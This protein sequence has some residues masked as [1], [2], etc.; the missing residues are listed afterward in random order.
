MRNPLIRLTSSRIALTCSMILAALSLG[1]RA[2]AQDSDGT[3]LPV[4]HPAAPPAA[5]QS[6][7]M[8]TPEPCPAEEQTPQRDIDV[9]DQV[10]QPGPCALPALS[11]V[12]GSLSKGEGTGHATNAGT[13]SRPGPTASDRDGLSVPPG[14]H[15]ETASSQQERR[16]YVSARTVELPFSDALCPAADDAERALKAVVLYVSGNRGRTWVRAQKRALPADSMSFTAANDGEFWCL[17]RREKRFERGDGPAAGA[18]PHRI[19]TVDTAPPIVARIE[20]L[21][22]ADDGTVTV[23]WEV[24]DR[25]PLVAMKAVVIH[26]RSGAVAMP[27]E[28]VKA[29]AG[30]ARFRLGERGLWHVGAQFAD[31]AGN[32]ETAT[33][34]LRFEPPAPAAA[35]AP[36]ETRNAILAPMAT[37]LTDTVP[38]EPSVA[39]GAELEPSAQVRARERIAVLPTRTLRIGYRWDAEHPPSRVGLWVTPDGGRTWRLDQVTDELTGSFLFEAAGDGPYGFRTHRELAGNVWDA[40]HSGLAPE[41]EI[42]V[43]TTAPRVVWTGPLGDETAGV[44][45]RAPTRV[46]GTV[47]LRWTVTEAFPADR[48]VTLAYRAFA[49]EAWHELAGPM[50]DAGQYDWQPPADLRGPV[51]VR[52]TA[53]DRAGH[54]TTAALPVEIGP[55]LA[56]APPEQPEPDEG[57]DAA[58]VKTSPS[59]A[60]RRAYAMATL[61]RL[62]ENWE[63]AEK[64]LARATALDP[65]YGRAWVDLGGI[66]L[67]SGRWESAVDVYRKALQLEPASGNAGLGLAR[68][69]AARGDLPGAAETLEK[70]LERSPDDADGWLLYGD[71]LYK[72]GNASRARQCWLKSMGLGGGHRANLAAIRQRL[73]LKQ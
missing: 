7:A 37:D 68:A 24:E 58:E 62:Q 28:M 13:D 8:P 69:L 9:P 50:A 22:A 55:A 42:I 64:Q 25:S 52:I 48:P 44:S 29:P 70:L 26:D 34:D 14:T 43:D 15:D 20:A 33:C 49:Q 12:E 45:G 40:P 2:P 31:A 73:Q 39:P 5:N 57:T 11:A 27:F 4:V 46:E 3:L 17:W 51:E 72:G 65:T 63:A 67:H 35:Q 19:V 53:A 21:P 41:R 10:P 32:A 59:D 1:A 60:A 71:V 56:A 54:A 66:Y 61:A 23:A 30:R 38:Q 16:I 36:T 6:A 47:P 18:E